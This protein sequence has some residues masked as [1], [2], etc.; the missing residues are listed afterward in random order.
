MSISSLDPSMLMGFLVRDR[1]D[2]EDLRRRL[3]NV[4]RS[5]RLK[6]YRR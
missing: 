1:E 2:W 4:S 5:A 3:N 6:G